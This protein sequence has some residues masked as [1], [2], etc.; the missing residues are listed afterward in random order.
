VGVEVQNARGPET[1][2]AA[3]IYSDIGAEA[4]YGKL[5]AGEFSLG[6]EQAEMA[7]TPTYGVVTLYLGLKSS[8][9][10]LGIHGQ[11]FWI[12]DS[13][14]HDSTW[15]RR[16]ELAQGRAT[17]C[18]LSFPGIKDPSAQMPTA[19][20]I[21]P[22]DYGFFRPWREKAW[23][24]RGLDYEAV[25]ERIATALLGFVESRIP[26]FRAEVSYS[27]LSTPL[28]VEN[29]TGHRDGGIYGFPGVPRRTGLKSL[30]S[31]TPVQGLTLVGADAGSLGIAGSMMAG[32]KGVALEH[33]MGV[34]FKVLQGNL[35]EFSAKLEKAPAPGAPL[36]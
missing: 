22:L 30:G 28:T 21:A 32:I 7:S 11:N 35:P 15:E 13:F 27:E 19:E 34:L 9:E 23:R 26:G 33:G 18:Y 14:D 25:K 12:Y 24:K 5:L 3:E 36:S 16:N 17:S 6:D 2:S 29:F 10:H 20:I 31:K 1:I 8:C 4:T